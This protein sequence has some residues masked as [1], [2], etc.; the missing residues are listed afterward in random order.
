MAPWNNRCMSETLSPSDDNSLSPIRFGDVLVDR[1]TRRLSVDG[2]WRHIEPQVFDVLVYLIEHRDRVVPK[3]ELLDQIWGSRFVSESALTSRIRSARSAVG[4]DGRR[5]HVI[6]TAHGT[7]YQFVGELDAELGAVEGSRPTPPSRPGGSVSR[8]SRPANPFRGRQADLAAVSDLLDRC[9]LVTVIGPGGTG[10]TRLATEVMVDRSAPAAFVDL[11]AV[12]DGSA[13]GQALISALGIEVGTAADELEAACAYLRSDPVALLVDNCEHVPVEAAELVRRLL[14][15]TDDVSVLA[16]SRVP[17]NL[18]DEQLYRLAPLPI[19]DH[20]GSITPTVARTS[21]A[22]ALFCDR[23]TQLAHEFELDHESAQHVVALCRALDGLP[24]ALELAAARTQTFGLQDLL[25]RLDDRLDL[26]DDDRH[27]TADRHRSLRATLNWSFDLLDSDCRELFVH[28]SVFPAGLT[29]DGVEW[30]V[31]RLGLPAP[32][33]VLLDRLVKVSLL[34]RTDH[35]SGVRYGQ[36]ETMRTFGID[37]LAEHGRLIATRD[38]Q[39]AWVFEFLDVMNAAFSSPWGVDWD[40]LVRQEWPNIRH[41]R[42]HLAAQARHQELVSV[43]LGLHDWGRL[44]DMSELWIWCDELRALIPLG[45]D[46]SDLDDVARCRIKAV[47]S[48]AAWRRG[49]VADTERL[50]GEVLAAPCDDWAVAAAHASHGVAGLF[51]GDM[52]AARNA[53]MTR[54]EID[55]SVLD[56]ANAGLATGYSGDVEEARR[57]SLR[58]YEEASEKGFPD[59]LAWTSYVC[60]EVQATAGDPAAETMLKSA[61]DQATAVGSSFT[62]GV[63]S[64]TLCTLMTAEGRIEE[65]AVRYRDL[66]THWLRSGTWTQLWTTLRNAATLIVQ[67]DPAVCVQVIDTA[68]DDPFAS[69][70]D[71]EASA[72]FAAIRSQAAA[73][74]SPDELAVLEARRLTMDRGELAA[75][76]RTSLE[77]FRPAT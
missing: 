35:R 63:A 50:A 76:V 69:A 41:A 49:R 10:K 13:V 60:G 14:A 34:E 46:E 26:L 11:A 8:F 64:V 17:L 28:L 62:Y 6:R 20:S 58:A 2:D 51:K 12:R 33:P 43:S 75:E 56:L 32:V 66:I 55:G 19:L 52:A 70:L 18:R 54:V 48:Q 29:L 38:L 73:L 23:V 39:A 25:H 45:P 72:Q 24:L 53:W 27:D 47:A 61:V 44:R 67:D 40:A 21:P 7:G 59:G 9:R 71:D 15:A 16:T 74:L 68:A 37:W 30:L 3:T 5:Q 42:R 31:E 22:V 77:S 65:V 4:D 57:L 36:L 1:S